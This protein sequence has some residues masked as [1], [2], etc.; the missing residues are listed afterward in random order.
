MLQ[1]ARCERPEIAG[2]ADVALRGLFEAPALHQAQRGVEDGF[3]GKAMGRAGFEAEDVAGQMEGA[4]LAAAVG[5]QLVGAHR[6]ANHL[7]DIVGLLILAVDFLVLAVGEFGG[8]EASMPGQHAEAVARCAGER[9]NLAADGGRSADRLGEHWASPHSGMTKLY[10]RSG[11]PEIWSDALRRIPYVVYRRG[12]LSEHDLVR[13]PVP[14]L[15]T[16]PCGSGSCSSARY[17][18]R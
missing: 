4:D 18:A 12:L 1:F 13:K 17:R 15:L 5:E 2:D 10:W 6:A 11:R 9:G 8:D 3:G 14:T 7:V 16:R